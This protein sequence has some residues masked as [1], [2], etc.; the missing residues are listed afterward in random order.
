MPKSHRPAFTLVELLTVLAIV[1]VL[2]SILIPVV[3]NIRSKANQVTCTSNL[4]QL[5]MTIISM[6]NDN[7]GILPAAQNK[8]PNPKD[9]EFW[10]NAVLDYVDYPSTEDFKEQFSCPSWDGNSNGTHWYLGYA[11]N[12][13]PAYLGDSSGITQNSKNNGNPMIVQANGNE[14]RYRLVEVAFPERTIMFLDSWDWHINKNMG[15]DPAMDRHEDCCNAVFYDGHV[16][17]MYSLEDVTHA[18]TDPQ[19]YTPARNSGQG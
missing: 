17:A 9:N 16:E 7:K 18:I 6:T 15:T 3:G 12:T 5:H 8:K 4:R 19:T 10:V 1:G 2:A 13:T 11:Y 14:H